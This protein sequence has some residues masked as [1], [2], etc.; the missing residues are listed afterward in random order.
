MKCTLLAYNP[1]GFK[2]HGELCGIEVSKSQVSELTSEVEISVSQWRER[3]LTEQYRYCLFD[4]RYEKI[5]EN[6]R[7]VSKA[8]VIVIGISDKGIREVIGNWII[9]SHRVSQRCIMESLKKED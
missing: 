5:R 8:V 4:A 6:G 9:N 3:K 2:H 7:I 1:Q